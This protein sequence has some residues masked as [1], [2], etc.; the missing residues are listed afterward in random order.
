MGLVPSGERGVVDKLDSPTC[1]QESARSPKESPDRKSES[2]GEVF[3]WSGAPGG[4]RTPDLLVRSQLLYPAELRARRT[5]RIIYLEVPAPDS[6]IENEVK[7]PWHGAPAEI[8]ARIESRGYRLVQTRALES[9]QLFYRAGELRAADQLLRL[10]HSGDRSIVT[11]KGPARRERHKSREEIEFTV[12]DPQAFSLVLERLGYQPAFRYEKYRS[13]FAAPDEPGF[14][15]IDET[16][17][18][19]FLE[20]EGPPDWVDATAARLGLSPAEYL[21]SS[22]A[23]LYEEYRRSTPGAAPNMVFGQKD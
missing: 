6:Y 2:I 19:V 1:Q 3:G 10:R 14:V 17:I 18:G 5:H 22:Y 11:Y 16:P 7:I 9:D 8:Q 4:T 21:T 12:S 20:L 23:K 13:K 15:T